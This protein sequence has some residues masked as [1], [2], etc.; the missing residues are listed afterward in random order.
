MAIEL[1]LAQLLCFWSC[2]EEAP[3]TIGGVAGVEE[4]EAVDV[5]SIP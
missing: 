2:G 4:K 3:R 1:S 5:M